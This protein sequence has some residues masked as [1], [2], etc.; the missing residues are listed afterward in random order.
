MESRNETLTDIFTEPSLLTCQSTGGD[1]KT[2]LHT[3]SLPDYSR[4][5]Q[6]MHPRT[7]HIHRESRNRV[8]MR[9]SIS[10]GS[11]RSV[12]KK[13]KRHGWA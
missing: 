8:L 2:E 6:E 7:P 1:G 5:R 11:G 3:P 12:K 13:L 9:S 4:R 10:G